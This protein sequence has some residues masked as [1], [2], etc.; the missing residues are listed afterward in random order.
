[1]LKQYLDTRFKDT[2]NYILYPDKLIIKT[3]VTMTT[4]RGIN[5][6]QPIDIIST[7]KDRQTPHEIIIFFKDDQDLHLHQSGNKPDIGVHR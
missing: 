6:I 2:S 5:E 1:M 7:S 3:G 4:L